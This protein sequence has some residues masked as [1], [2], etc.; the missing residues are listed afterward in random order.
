M[1][2]GSMDAPITILIP[3]MITPITVI[4][5]LIPMMITTTMDKGP[6]GS[7]CRECHRSG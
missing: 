6:P 1:R 2:M 3:I 5:I 7:A 4:I